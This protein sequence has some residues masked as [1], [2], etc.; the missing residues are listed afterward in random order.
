MTP[1]PL[2]FILRGMRS[3]CFIFLK[4]K[5]LII[6]ASASVRWCTDCKELKQCAAEASAL[7][8]GRAPLGR[9]PDCSSIVP[10]VKNEE[11]KPSLSTWEVCM[12]TRHECILALLFPINSPSRHISY[13]KRAAWMGVKSCSV[14]QVPLWMCFYILITKKH[15]ISLF[16]S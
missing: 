1:A 3:K 7:S 15:F 6:M 4:A 12:N 14:S 2:Y 13:L 9:V 11:L 5:F 10:L 8:E 16:F